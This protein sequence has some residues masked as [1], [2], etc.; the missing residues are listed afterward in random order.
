ML[1]AANITRSGYY[2]KVVN[3]ILPP[4]ISSKLYFTF[5]FWDTCLVS[6]CYAGQTGSCYAPTAVGTRA[7]GV[8][9]VLRLGWSPMSAPAGVSRCKG[10]TLS[11]CATAI[12]NDKN[13][14]E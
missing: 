6:A 3:S 14:T 8:V 13:N 1:N 10:G 2:N 4:R 9:A 7:V 5:P 12:S 11:A